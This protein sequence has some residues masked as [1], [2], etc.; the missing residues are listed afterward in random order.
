MHPKRKLKLIW[1]LCLILGSAI[2]VALVLYAL[3]QNIN[4]YLTPSQIKVSE[5]KP[6]QLIRVGGL[7]V[8]GSVHHYPHSVKTSFVLTDNKKNL[9]V[10]YEGILP[11][12]FREGQGIIA[13]GRLNADKELMATEVLA[14]HDE[15][16]RPPRI[17]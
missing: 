2:I 10:V 12:L 11:S 5:L 14:K 8:K 16:Y 4:L 17:E 13:E 1:V 15:E 6:Q 3:K 9:T 7:V